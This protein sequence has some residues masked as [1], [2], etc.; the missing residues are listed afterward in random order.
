MFREKVGNT[1]TTERTGPGRRE[2]R[3][4]W[5]R[6]T[7]FQPTPQSGN[8]VLAERRA[9]LF[10]TLAAAADVGAVVKY[11]VTTAEP[12]H[13]RHAKP[14]LSHQHQERSIASP[15]PRAAI[16]CGNESFNLGSGQELD[17]LALA[18]L[19]GN[20]EYA[21]DLPAV[22]RLLECHV[23]KE[24]AQRRQ[25]CVS[26]ASAIASLRFEVIKELYEQRNIQVGDRQFRRRFA[27]P[28]L[29]ESQK[30]AK[31]IAVTRDRVW[32]RLSLSHETI[33]EEGLQ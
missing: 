31:G 3:F 17:G 6:L 5:R 30:Q 10:A 21:L 25:A 20:G 27:N 4:S 32:A 14:G 15:R 11:D 29:Y 18:F 33:G 9:A 1:V 7:F 2:Q 13:L 23:A 28:A 19:A 24:R 12:G 26:A 22:G 16:R 8:G